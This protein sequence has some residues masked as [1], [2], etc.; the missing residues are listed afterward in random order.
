MTTIDTRLAD[1]VSAASALAYA[2][3]QDMDTCEEWDDLNRA[4]L[5]AE[6]APP[7][8]ASPRYEFRGDTLMRFSTLASGAPEDHARER[9]L[10]DRDQPQFEKDAHRVPGAHHRSSLA[11][12]PVGR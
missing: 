9:P 11:R 7:T 3:E 8:D 10:D 6:E 4:V 12:S 5:A 2:R 1:L